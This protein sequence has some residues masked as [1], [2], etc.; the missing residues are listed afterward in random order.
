MDSRGAAKN[1]LPKHRRTPQDPTKHRRTVTKTP[2]DTTKHRKT[3]Q[4]SH[5]NTAGHYKTP[6]DSHENTVHFVNCRPNM[7]RN[8]AV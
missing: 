5:E 2:Q 7:L 3:P 1:G 6:Q 4:D 8:T